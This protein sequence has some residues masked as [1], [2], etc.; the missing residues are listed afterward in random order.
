MLS[1]LWCWRILLRVPWAAKRSNQFF[2]KEINPEYSLQGLILKLKLQYF[3]HLMG[4]D[5]SL[6]KTLMLGKT[7]GRRRRSDRGWNGWMASLTQWTWVWV[8]SG[9]WQWTGRPGVLQFRG[10]QRVR[11]NWATELNW[12]DLDNVK[13]KLLL[14]KFMACSWLC[15]MH[16]QYKVWKTCEK[17]EIFTGYPFHTLFLFHECGLRSQFGIDMYTLLY[18]KWITIRDLLCSTGN[19]AQC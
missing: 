18:L 11:H 19:S 2:L 16:S 5:D 10:S 8:N 12:I 17:T 4:R 3:G 13:N 15:L 14:V 7:E 9:S 1:K 6:E